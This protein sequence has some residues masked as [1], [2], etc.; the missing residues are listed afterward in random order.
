MEKSEITKK[1]TLIFRDVFNDSSLEINEEMTVNDVDDW[2]S[3]T[4]ML[5]ILDV[6]EAFGIKFKLKDLNIIRKVGDIVDII[7]QYNSVYL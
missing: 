3:L 5:M 2:N 6:E 7:Y 4:H 1:L